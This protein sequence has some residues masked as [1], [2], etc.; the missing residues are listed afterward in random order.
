MGLSDVS[1]KDWKN[2]KKELMDNGSIN[3]CKVVRI[4]KKGQ[5]KAREICYG[6]KNNIL[7]CMY[8]PST[9]YVI[10]YNEVD[11]K[12]NQIGGWKRE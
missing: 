9:E 10:F 5:K 2:L 1:P 6:G 4:G 11:D 3:K 8:N 7:K 12:G